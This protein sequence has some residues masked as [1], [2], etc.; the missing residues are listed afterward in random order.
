M[1]RVL[2]E[3]FTE[4][5]QLIETSIEYGFVFYLCGEKFQEE[6]SKS[7]RKLND[8]KSLINLRSYFIKRGLISDFEI[9]SLLTR[10]NHRLIGD[11]LK[12]LNTSYSHSLADFPR[13]EENLN[14]FLSLDLIN[15]QIWT[16]E[17]LKRWT[18]YEKLFRE[19]DKGKIT[20]TKRSEIFE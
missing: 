7:I 16:K 4:I 9:S 10:H 13:E 12:G 14:L 15:Y 18:E 3:F 20:L 1:N 17:Y 19:F 2:K 6:D 11:A 5:D 8:L